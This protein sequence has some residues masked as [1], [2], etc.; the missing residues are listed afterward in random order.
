MLAFVASLCIGAG[1]SKSPPNILWLHVESTDGRLY[2]ADSPVPIPNIRSV[3]ARGVNFDN[4]YANVPICCPSR[5]SVWTG[6]QPHRL[7]HEMNGVWVPGAISNY[8]GIGPADTKWD[9]SK[10]SDLLAPTYE[11]VIGG[12]EDWLSGGHSLT[13]MV[14]SWSVYARF[15]YNMPENAGNHIWGDCGGNLTVNPGNET[16]HAHDWKVATQQN[17][18]L[19]A[20][21]TSRE[22]PFFMYGG[23]V[24]VHPPYATSE[25]W[26][27][28]IDRSKIRVP[29]WEPLEDLHPCDLQTSMKK[30]CIVGKTTPEHPGGTAYLDTDEH[31]RDVIT[32]YYA[33]IAEY[34]AMVGT[35]LE[36]LRETGIEDDTV[37]ILTSDHGDMQMQHRQFYKMVAYEASTRVPCVIAG[38]GVTHRGSVQSLASLVDLMPTMLDIGQRPIPGDLDGVSLVPLLQRGDAAADSHPDHVVSQFHGENLVMSWYMIRRADLKLVVWGTGAEH[39]PQ[40]FNLT[41]DPDEMHN[42]ALKPGYADTVSE[43]D[44]LLRTEINYPN[45]S[46]AVA[47]YNIEMAQWWMRNES[48]Y[49]SILNGTEMAKYQRGP[50]ACLMSHEKCQGGS[51]WGEVWRIRNDDY[52]SAWDAWIEAGPRVVPCPD[53]LTY[54]WT[55]RGEAAVTDGAT[56]AE[57]PATVMYNSSELLKTRGEIRAGA[58]PAV[59]APYQAMLKGAREA[60]PKKGSAWDF[61]TGPWSVRNKTLTLPNISSN[62]YIS[63]G[64]YNHPCNALPSGCRPYPSGKPLPPSKCDNKTGLPWVPCDGI[65][66]PSAIAEG[67]SPRAEKMVNAVKQLALGA[68]FC[69]VTSD[70]CEAWASR[71]AFILRVW[72]LEPDTAMLPNLFYGQIKP[73]ASPPKPGHGG[74]IEWTHMTNLIDSVALLRFAYPSVWT[75]N[76][77]QAL[78]KWFGQFLEYI[79]SKPAQGERDMTNNHGSWFDSTWT[80]V[81]LYAGNRTDAEAAARDVRERRIDY[82]LLANGTEWI[83][84]ERNNA[85]GYCQYNAL[86]LARCATAARNAGTDDGLWTYVGKKGGSIRKMLDWLLPYVAS[87]VKWPYHQ[88]S[89]AASWNGMFTVYRLASIAYNN[90]TYEW[91]ACK[92]TKPSAGLGTD[93][94]TDVMNL[95]LPPRFDV[96]C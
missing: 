1:A 56:K 3:Q 2:N 42:L 33:M 36:T 57:G 84:I 25:F 86:A 77:D 48:N 87:Q 8:E 14:D 28:R 9:H 34:D 79:D 78:R 23:F 39:P 44:A 32:G 38:P 5:A 74:F 68:F 96:T 82:Q 16:A 80:S 45:V 49:Q 88:G 71:A 22:K 10:I 31:K 89:E 85:A 90:Q 69:N 70:E 59:V 35:Y 65:R 52:Q 53:S 67:D 40:L 50:Q 75:D 29:K 27:N 20:N 64:I 47:K 6:R 13:T 43:L 95:L 15:P 54:N 51:D 18:W 26:Y 30:G 7:E 63:I 92:A 62:N 41:A 37:V 55:D 66:N 58:N 60:M 81:A 17:E 73:N 19:R 91:A 46:L 61:T 94:K 12:K 4:F 11:V 21:G 83:E 76:D 72:F 93:Y 24:I